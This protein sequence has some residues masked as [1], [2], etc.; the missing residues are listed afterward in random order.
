MPQTN[1]QQATPVLRR[2][3]EQL[4]KIEIEVETVGVSMGAVTF[5]I[6]PDSAEQALAIADELMYQVKASGKH[7]FIQQEY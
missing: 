7:Q 3:F 2:L 4:S 6:F 5:Q 1:R